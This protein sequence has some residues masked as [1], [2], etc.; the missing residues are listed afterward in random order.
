M[1]Q[2]NLVLILARGLADE[3]ASAMFLVDAEGTLVYFNDP[4]A[5]ILGR[6]FGETGEIKMQEWSTAFMP[7]STDGKPLDPDALPLVVA[8]KHRRISH[9]AFRIQGADGEWRE[10]AAT[11]L[12]LFAGQREFVGALAIFWEN[13]AADAAVES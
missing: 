7:Q 12:P 1:Y 6:S 9:R 11:A 10:I 5:Q 13:G 8:V 4:A 3:V 2:K